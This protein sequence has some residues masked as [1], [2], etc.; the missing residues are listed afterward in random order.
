MLKLSTPNISFPSNLTANFLTITLPTLLT[1]TLLGSA[2]E[3]NLILKDRFVIPGMMM[4]S[5]PKFGNLTNSNWFWSIS[6]GLCVTIT[7]CL[8][9]F[10]SLVILREWTGFN[11]FCIPFY[12]SH[13]MWRAL[14][15]PGPSVIP[16]SF[17]SF[18]LRVKEASSP[19]LNLLYWGVT[20]SKLINSSEPVM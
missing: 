12:G 1:N 16:L 10:M 15:I 18:I 13:L 17:W 3:D 7:F 6:L 5:L 9:P 14:V 8:V 4:S 20:G 11:F 19:C 2:G